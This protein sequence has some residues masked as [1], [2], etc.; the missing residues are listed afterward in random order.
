MYSQ[1]YRPEPERQGPLAIIL[2]LIVTC[3]GLTGI[4]LWTIVLASKF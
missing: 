2:N 3:A 1:G 4:V